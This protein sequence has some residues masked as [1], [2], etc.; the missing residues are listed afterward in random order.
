MGL[1]PLYVLLYYI[2]SPP[3]LDP[4]IGT[5]DAPLS[6]KEER[7]VLFFDPYEEWISCTFPSKLSFFI[8]F[9]FRAQ[10]SIPP[11]KELR[12]AVLEL[13]LIFICNQGT[14]TVKKC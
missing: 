12:N 1:I 6:D 8:T 14:S 4:G 11:I 3:D 10:A 5:E 9:L 7:M 13:Q 2:Y